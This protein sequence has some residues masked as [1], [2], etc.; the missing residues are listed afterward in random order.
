MFK[1]MNDM[2]IVIAIEALRMAFGTQHTALWIA[3]FDEFMVRIP[4]PY[5]RGDMMYRAE[6]SII[7][8]LYPDTDWQEFVEAEL[9][10][11]AEDMATW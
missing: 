11:Q 5:T 8:E 7:M 4:E 9:Q 10:A 1:H 3:L 2:Q 6:K